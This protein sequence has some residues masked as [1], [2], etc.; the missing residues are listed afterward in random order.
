MPNGNYVLKYSCGQA[1]LF[2]P[3]FFLAHCYAKLNDTFP[4]DG[5]S[6]PSQFMISMGCLLMAFLGMWVLRRI[7]LRYFSDSSVAVSLILLVLGTNYFE[8]GTLGSALTHSN[9]FTLY[10]LLILLTI[11][12]YEKPTYWKAVGIGG[13]VG[14]AA[15]VRPTEILSALIP[16]LWGLTP[17]FR[18]SL[19]DKMEF[20]KRIYPSWRLLLPPVFWWVRC[21]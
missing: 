1:I 15:L 10:A 12:F 8:Y 7:L 17:N 16:L 11:R 14:L 5:F 3:F 20:S 13:L 19:A 2:S 4:A 21:N 18:S 9:L 6:V